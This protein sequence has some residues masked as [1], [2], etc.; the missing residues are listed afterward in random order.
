MNGLVCRLGS[1]RAPVSTDWTAG[2][3]VVELKNGRKILIEG[4]A[5]SHR[6][7]YLTALNSL[8]RRTLYLRFLSPITEISDVQ[9]DRFLDVGHDGREA[10]VAVSFDTDEIVGVAR[11][12]TDPSRKDQVEIALMVVD[13]WQ[14][15][16]VGSILLDRLIELAGRCG[17]R[18][19]GATSLA[20]NAV[21]KSMLRARGFTALTS[22]GVTEWALHLSPTP[23]SQK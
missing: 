2:S 9:V 14:F 13:A 16:G 4:L 8:S 20:E 10:L 12:A 5:R 21:V 19:V 18:V 22:L 3:E 6:E 7:R 1:G 23:P 15:Q 17:Y 11:F